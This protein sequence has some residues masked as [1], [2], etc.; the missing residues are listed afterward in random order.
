MN[1]KMLLIS[2]FG[3]VL[4]PSLANLEHLLRTAVNDR[5]RLYSYQYIFESPL[6]YLVLFFSGLL[7][8]TLYEY[9][10]WRKKNEK[11]NKED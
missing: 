3:L 11:F 8:H 6:I 2:I 10:L 9:Y 7:A 4:M 1:K 5:T